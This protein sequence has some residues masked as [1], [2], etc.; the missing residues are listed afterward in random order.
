MEKLTTDVYTREVI[1]ETVYEGILRLEAGAEVWRK[2]GLIHRDSDQPAYIS[3]STTAWFANGVRHR[4]DDRPAVV[5]EGEMLEWYM[6]GRLH[7][8]ND[9]PARVF[10]NGSEW[11]SSSQWSASYRVSRWK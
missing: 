7:R 8:G 5:I 10:S 3:E 1:S 6:N 11:L 4:E 2:N 9:R